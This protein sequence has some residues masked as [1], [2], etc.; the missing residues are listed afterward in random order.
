MLTVAVQRSIAEVQASLIIA[1][2]FPRD[3]AA[4][5]KR[6]Q[7]ACGDVRLAE[8]AE[9][10]YSRGGTAIVGPSIRLAEVVAMNW[11]NIDFGIREIEQRRDG[12]TVQAFAWDKETN[13]RSEVTFEAKAIRFTK[14]GSYD[15][16]DPRDI[17][18]N[19]ANLGAR[20]LRARIM[21]VIPRH[22]FDSAVDACHAT[23]KEKTPVTPESVAKLVDAFAGISVTKA[24]LEKF[25]GRACDAQT[26]SAGHVARLR[27]IYASVRDKVG[28]VSDFFQVDTQAAQTATPKTGSDALR[29]AVQSQPQEPVGGQ[30]TPQEAG[31]APRASRA[32]RTPPQPREPG[33]ERPEDVEPAEQGSLMEPTAYRDET[34]RKKARSFMA[35]ALKDAGLLEDDDRHA[36]CKAAFG[37]DGLKA[38]SDTDLLALEDMNQ[39]GDLKAEVQEWLAKRTA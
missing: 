16:E 25:L 12:S 2:K 8:D 11:G 18:E 39:R 22:V 27:R 10:E 33:D 13:T 37:V 5:I 9:Y 31:K 17:Y 1:K 29:A 36:F 14:K 3:P 23:Q 15:L 34:S 28:T 4:S 24:M 26:V 21:A 19:V 38:M 6:I 35:L 30:E 32:P 20:R 7:A